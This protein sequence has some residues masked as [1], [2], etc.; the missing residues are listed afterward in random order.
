MRCRTAIGL[1]LLWCL[2]WLAGSPDESAAANRLY[3]CP[4]KGGE[5]ILSPKNGPGCEPLDEP[6]AR[7]QDKPKKEKKKTWDDITY[8]NLETAVASFDRKY[9][10]FL[11]CCASDPGSMNELDALER[12]ATD[13]IDKAQGLVGQRFSLAASHG[14]LVLPVVQART[15]LREL[16]QRQQQLDRAYEK[17]QEADYE[18][19][20]REKRKIRED[21]AA[22]TKEFAA[23]TQFDRAPSGKDIGKS[24]LNDSSQTGAG[25]SGASSFNKQSSVGAASGNSDLNQS[26]RTGSTDVGSSRLN[27]TSKTGDDLGATSTLNNA[28]RVG[29]A[30]GD[31]SS[32]NSSSSTGRS[33]GKS[34]LNSPSP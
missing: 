27:E 3:L 30:L 17:M 9:R 32:F 12:E 15:K 18:T 19:S 6:P 29:P 33:I 4:G 22:L 8:D 34:D 5:S 14:A 11:S 25:L 23:P 26:S 10:D 20:G 7:P 31:T 24:R 28:S 16:R 13:I 21:E 1:V 2:A